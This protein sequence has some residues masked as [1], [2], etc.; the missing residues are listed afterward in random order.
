MTVS[1][2]PEMTS[3]PHLVENLAHMDKALDKAVA[4][5]MHRVM[6]AGVHA[7]QAA[8]PV[9]RGTLRRSFAKDSRSDKDSATIGTSVSYAAYQD[10]AKQWGLKAAGWPNVVSLRG[11]VQRNI[12]PPAKELYAVTYLVGRSLFKRGKPKNAAHFMQAALEAMRET[13]NHTA[14]RE[15]NED[16]LKAVNR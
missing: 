13:A 15:F 11:W 7:A 9:D 2:K 3:P 4:A 1:F 12:K 6:E 5:Y 10:G 16:T 14:M 8:A